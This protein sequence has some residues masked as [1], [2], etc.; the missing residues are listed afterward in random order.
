[1]I[2]AQRTAF[3]T[4]AAIV[5]LLAAASVACAQDSP[6]PPVG[7]APPKPKVTRVNGEIETDGLI[8]L[9][10][11]HLAEWISA[12]NDPHKLI[13]Y[14]NGLGL[15]RNYPE[16]ID[17]AKNLL[18]FH[19]RITPENKETWVDLL[20][21]PKALRHPVTFSVGLENQSPF[22]TVFDSGN[23]LSLVVVERFYGVIALV[24]VLVALLVFVRLAR[25]TNLIREAAPETV[26][27]LLR[28]YNLGRTQMAFWFFLVCISYIVIWLITGALDTITSS[29]L[30]L[31]GISAGTALG[32]AMIDADKIDAKADQLITLTARK[33][34]IDQGLAEL[35]SQPSVGDPDRLEEARTRQFK[36]SQQL[37][38]LA[39]SGSAAR[40]RGFLRDIMSG[41]ADY[42]LHRFQ[43]VVWTIVLGII[44]LSSV[45]E[46][47]TMPEFSATLLGLMGISS[48]TY[49]GFKF[50]EKK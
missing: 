4:F 12:N 8:E 24:V 17:A 34:A 13:P 3:S 14:V 33:Q 1:M 25:T 11:D 48:G 22:D 27:G 2:M 36:I 21:A 41:G 35:K 40:S 26:D 5:L 15:R 6:A 44:F 38:K 49:I 20:G 43:I 39:P 18:R 28:P 50:P 37:A 32:E 9:N 30:G 19:L 42:S 10:V 45:Y 16:E 31:M 47:L 29:L 7:P 46:T 23:Q